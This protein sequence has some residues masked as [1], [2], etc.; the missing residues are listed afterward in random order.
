MN[1]NDLHVEPADNSSAFFTD[2]SGKIRPRSTPETPYPAHTPPPAP[3]GM[4]WEYRGRGWRSHRCVEYYALEAVGGGITHASGPSQGVG[5]NHYFEAVP[6]QDLP[7]PNHTPPPAPEGMKWEYRGMGWTRESLRPSV[8]YTLSF[9]QM[10]K[11]PVMRRPQGALDQHYF[12]AVPILKDSGFLFA[13]KQSPS[14]PKAPDTLI[15]TPLDIAAVNTLLSH[16]ITLLEKW[17]ELRDESADSPAVELY[18]V[19]TETWVVAAH[20]FM[21]AGINKS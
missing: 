21:S 13:N 6:M 5:S 12:E 3:E 10:V 4:K 19:L 15:F 7:Y 16:G 18:G 9:K 8:Y 11:G 2:E 14:M 20:A 1:P 17:R